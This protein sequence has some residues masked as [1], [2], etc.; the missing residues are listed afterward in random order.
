MRSVRRTLAAPL[1]AGFIAALSWRTIAAQGKAPPPG[2]RCARVSEP[3]EMPPLDYLVDVPT[4]RAAVP[5]FDD[6]V[7]FFSI[8]FEKNGYPRDPILAQST[9]PDSLR[10]TLTLAVRATLRDQPNGNGFTLLLRVADGKPLQ[11]ELL[12]S[13]ECHA[14][15]SGSL[16]EIHAWLV[17]RNAGRKIQD[18][19]MFAEVRVDSGGRALDAKVLGPPSFQNIPGIDSAVMKHVSFIPP[20]Y[21]GQ[22]IARVDTV[23]FGTAVRKP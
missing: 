18:W 20:R 11:L 23:S 16:D 7:A 17:E 1:L 21:D 22:A 12:H 6:G 4:L 10:E 3:A 14:E 2:R 8:A 5:R 9:Y 19:L 13:L 15:Q